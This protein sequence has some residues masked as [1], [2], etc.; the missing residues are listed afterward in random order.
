MEELT[1]LA[2]M[3]A[4]K[5]RELEIVL[6]IDEIRDGAVP[7]VVMLSNIVNVLSDKFE[8]DFCLLY[9]IN[10]E[11]GT[12]DLKVINQQDHRWGILGVGRSLEMAKRAIQVENVTLWDAESVFGTSLP[13]ECPPE[14]KFVAIPIILDEP[15]GGILMARIARPFDSDDIQVLKTAESQIDS[16]VIQTY[17]YHEL[18]QRY[19]EL[20]TIYRVDHI[21][22]QQLP[23]DEMLNVVL[24][25]LCQA[26]DAEIGFVMLYDD[27]GEQLQMRAITQSEF[28]TPSPDYELVLALSNEAVQTGE[29]ICH[30]AAGQALCSI[31][32]VPLILRDEV[33]GVFG[34]LSDHEPHQG[35][36]VDDRRLLRAI[37]SQMDTA[38]LESL[39]KRRLRRVL[40][41]SV[42]PHVLKVLLEKSDVD[43]LKGERR[44][45]S[46]LYAD[47]RGSTQLAERSE[48]EV[49]VEFINSYLAE[50]TEV[51]LAN[52]GT[53]DKFVG[54][55]V[56][57]LFGAP[58]SQPDHALRAARVGL[59]MQ[60]AHQ[61]LLRRWE[62]Q[63]IAAAGIG[64][65]IATGELIV[66]EIGCEKRTD[67]T[68][69]GRAA[70]LGAR[71]C[72][73]AK[74]GQVLISQGTYDLIKDKVEVTPVTGQHFKGIDHDVTVYNVHRIL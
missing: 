73:V 15:L 63:G 27:E 59:A 17:T 64:I 41:R 68:V 33:I 34:A 29:M 19:K 40:G 6:M 55:E 51:L 53:L 49:L 70:N 4:L 71:I 30:N 23:F 56:M 62:E 50:M 54:D 35:F 1:N 38:I 14:M 60:A 10:R 36:S 69:I 45:L 5:E 8:T 12:L 74:S 43:I 39:E 46:V 11:T 61:A 44:V 52:G 18:K 67:Y 21:R 32:C 26:I 13:P 48:P 58:M 3:L 22:D 7:P 37:V 25:E 2:H 28:L 66:G 16:A 57:A 24:Q 65:G 42:D 9:L 47:L 72:A 20:D 31:M